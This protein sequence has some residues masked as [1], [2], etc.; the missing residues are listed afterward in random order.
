MKLHCT[1]LAAA[2]TAAFAAPLAAQESGSFIVRLG[3]D[4]T[5][6]ESYTRT[7]DRLVVNQVGR[8]PRVLTRRFQYDMNA[9]GAAVKASATIT[10]PTAAAGTAPVQQIDATFEGDSLTMVSVRDTS[11][12]RVRLPLSA[13][14]VANAG[15]SSWSMYEQLSLRMVAG[16]LDSLR[17]PMYSLG[18]TSLTRVTVGKHGR[19]SIFVQTEN[20]RYHARVDAKG[21]IQNVVPVW[22]TVR[23]NV[24]R[25]AKLDLPA[26]VASFAGREA[27]GAG[28]GALST[29]DTARAETA[30]AKVWIDYGRPAKRGRVIF[31]TVV[32][33]GELW[34][35]GANATTQ[36]GTDQPLEIGG[37]TL[38]AGTYSLFTIPS[39]TAW[40]LLINSEAGIAGTAHKAEKDLHTLDMKVTQLPETIERF[41]IL[42]EPSATG[43]TIHMQWDNTR[44]SIPF[45]V[46]R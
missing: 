20:D 28:M 23:V 34:R 18:S 9:A 15:G 10:N 5:G 26:L 40:K 19:D 22:G 35:T 2:L 12:Q 36:L 33:F 16:K 43:G 37:V 30:G 31:G 6:I 27:A 3:R 13:G 17:L 11:T 44:A 42:I 21:H 45:A 25:V 1:I 8:A 14:L 41:T 39:P 4:T 32:P 38:P 24:D 7:G 46:K 29:R